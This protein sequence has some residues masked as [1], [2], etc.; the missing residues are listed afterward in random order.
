MFNHTGIYYSIY[1]NINLSLAF[2]M[3]LVN[4]GNYLSKRVENPFS[5]LIPAKII[6]N[7]EA[8]PT[9]PVE[10]DG[11]GWIYKPATKEIRLNWAGTDE[12]GVS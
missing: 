5:G 3:Q 2:F 6:T 7:T 9:E 8:F 4:D 12:D 11:Y 10:T 1:F